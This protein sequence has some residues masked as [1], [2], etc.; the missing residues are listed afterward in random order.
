MTEFAREG[1]RLTS[2]FRMSKKG[3]SWRDRDEES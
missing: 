3:G 2:S 1:Y